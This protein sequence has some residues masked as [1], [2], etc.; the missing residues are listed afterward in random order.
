[1]ILFT[2]V[3]AVLVIAYLLGSIPTALIVSKRIKRMDI[4]SVGD[5]NMGAV[6]IFHQ[7]GQ[8]FGVMVGVIDVVKGALSVFLAYILGLHQGWQILAGILVILGHDFLIFANFKGGQ[9]AATSLGTML[10]LFPVPILIAL[11]P[12]G[13][14]FLIKRN[15]IITAIVGGITIVLTLGIFHEWLLLGYAV[16]VFIFIPIKLLIDSPRR[17]AI[18]TAKSGKI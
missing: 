9:G 8:K 2:K 16:A 18:E 3:A 14:V 12:C 7:I 1:M 10:V 6:N 5:G 17:R 13:I 11:I 15:S 4:R